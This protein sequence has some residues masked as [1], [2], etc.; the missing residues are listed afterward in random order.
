MKKIVSFV[1]VIFLTLNFTSFTFADTSL[2]PS[3]GDAAEMIMG[4]RQNGTPI[5][6]LM[7][8]IAVIVKEPSVQEWYKTVTILAYEE[9]SYGT[10]EMQ[11]SMI[12]E[13][14]NEIELMCYKGT[15]DFIQ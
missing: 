13:F 15:I 11:Q 1:L 3:L 14:R 2:C 7:E 4:H 5:S 8:G 9:P 12:A 6:T 10:N